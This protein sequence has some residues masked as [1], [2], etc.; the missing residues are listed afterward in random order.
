VS[1][2]L[3]RL[4]IA[5]PGVLYLV[6]QWRRYRAAR[7]DPASD[8]GL[9]RSLAWQVRLLI[10]ALFA[11]AAIVLADVAGMPTAVIGAILLFA[12]A[13]VIALAVLIA[14]SKD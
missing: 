4:L 3:I 10:A 14:G 9:L 5:L 7:A 8:P 12:A 6:R 11:L 1:V 13:D 2:E